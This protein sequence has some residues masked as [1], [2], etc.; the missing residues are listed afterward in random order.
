MGPHFYDGRP[1]ETSGDSKKILKTYFFLLSAKNTLNT[2]KREG[3]II[4]PRA[5]LAFL[6]IREGQVES[7][8]NTPLL[9]HIVT[10]AYHSN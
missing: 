10:R 7:Q 6:G 4:G 5:N 9:T 2:P 8:I 1:V 3:N